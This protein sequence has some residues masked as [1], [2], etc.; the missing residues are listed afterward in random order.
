MLLEE[1]VCCDQCVFLAELYEPLPASF[2]IPRPNLPVA[3]GVSC[4]P[5]LHSS[6]LEWKGHLSWV[7][8]LEGLVG[9]HRTS[10]S[11]ALLAGV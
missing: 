8:V 3:P 4:L 11:S 5:T 7:L 10:A 2:R 6:P 9:L 1:A